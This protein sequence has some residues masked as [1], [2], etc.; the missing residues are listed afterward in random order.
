VSIGE[1]RPLDE[2]R[3]R[4]CLSSAKTGKITHD[5][6]VDDTVL[7]RGD[8]AIDFNAYVAWETN[9]IE[10]LD[11][12][13]PQPRLSHVL[14]MDHSLQLPRL[15]KKSWNDFSKRMLVWVQ[16][17]DEE[18]GFFSAIRWAALELRDSPNPWSPP[19]RPWDWTLRRTAQRVVNPDSPR[20][21]Y[22]SWL[23]DYIWAMAWTAEGSV[24][25]AKANMTA[26]YALARRIASRLNKT[27]TRA[28]LAAAEAIM[29]VDVV[30]ASEPW[31]WVQKLLVEDP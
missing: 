3:A 29:I 27:G 8:K 1:G 14:G 30:G 18:D 20:R 9:L 7:W 22:G 16:D 12:A 25:Q 19:M 28:D 24:Y 11:G 15:R 5:V 17:E 4:A 26:R 23:A 13:G 21:I 6:K 2:A 31:E 10:Q